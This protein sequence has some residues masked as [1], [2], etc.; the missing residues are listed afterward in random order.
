MRGCD[1]LRSHV[2]VGLHTGGAS[3]P[4]L[5]PVEVRVSL[6]DLP[7]PSP[8]GGPESTS[9]P[10]PVRVSHGVFS[11]ALRCPGGFIRYTEKSQQGEELCELDV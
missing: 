7:G 11:C 3:P 6:I 4:M 8:S 9:V 1:R 5:S 10:S 2:S